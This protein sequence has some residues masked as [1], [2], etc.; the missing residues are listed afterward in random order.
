MYIKIAVIVVLDSEGT[1][2]QEG[3][4]RACKCVA[5]DVHHG[6][7]SQLLVLSRRLNTIVFRLQGR[8]TREVVVDDNAKPLIMEE[9]Q[10]SAKPMLCSQGG[11]VIS[12]SYS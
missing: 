6:C 9:M 5:P 8:P 3:Y 11:G 10:R 12:G 7:G 1:G 2:E 4:R